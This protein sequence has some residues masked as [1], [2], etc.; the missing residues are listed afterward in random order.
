MVTRKTSQNNSDHTCV[1]SHSGTSSDAQTSF[2]SHTDI[3]VR[4][5]PK[6]NGLPGVGLLIGSNCPVALE[7]M[8]VAP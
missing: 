5:P 4:V 7:P 6:S 3:P 2:I 8:E 1:T